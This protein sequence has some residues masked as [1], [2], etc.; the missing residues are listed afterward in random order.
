MIVSKAVNFGLC[1]TSEVIWSLKGFYH[2]RRNFHEI[3]S[4]RFTD[5][6]FV[7]LCMSTVA[8]GKTQ[9]TI[10]CLSFDPHVNGLY[11]GYQA[12]MELNPD[13]MLS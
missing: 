13:M 12:F 10:W 3:K 11:G 5:G 7:V 6:V 8:L 9:I 4:I 1:N 2:G